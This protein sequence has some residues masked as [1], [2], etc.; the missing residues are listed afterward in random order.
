V[1]KTNLSLAKS[2]EIHSQRNG[3]IDSRVSSLIQQRGSQ[4]RHGEDDEPRL[5][6]AVHGCAGEEAEGPFP[7]EHEDAEDEVDDLEDGE[8]LHCAVEILG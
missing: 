1:Q 6:G 8:G 2:P 3:I 4:G 7:G 5:D